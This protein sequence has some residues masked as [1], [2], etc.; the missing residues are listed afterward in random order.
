MA[1]AE[2]AAWLPLVALRGLLGALPPT[3][4]L[5]LAAA[6]GRLYVGL[7]G[8]R[9][10]DALVNLAIAFPERP[11]SELRRVRAESFA[12]LGRG[13]AEVCLMQGR[14]REAVL[15]SVGLE[16]LGHLEA[17][18]ARSATGGALVVTAH[19]GSW[20]LCAAAVASHGIPVTVV[21]HGIGNARVANMVKSWREG[22]GLET[23]ELGSSARGVLDAL[24]RG[25]LVAFLM[26][27]NARRNE[28]VFAP[29]FG[30]L[31]CTRSGPVRIA[32]K[33]GVPLLPI[34]FHRSKGAGGH[35]ARFESPLEMEPEG[36]DAQQA[37]RSNVERMNAVIEDQ[38]RRAPEHW[39][40]SHR[41]WKTRPE[42]EAR[43]LYPSRRLE[44]K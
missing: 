37:L 40:W 11:E 26:D 10:R 20:E 4:S 39:I 31:A 34:F 17:A 3:A 15:G 2:L 9:T 42:G 41:R 22:G 43:G 36:L 18:R 24:N 27:Q 44:P 38:I 32:M 1:V 16:G 21:Y 6:A 8:P 5:S 29:F 33:Q 13:L 30:E 28:G 19:F 35:V 25:R 23:L 12:N 14:N 7:H